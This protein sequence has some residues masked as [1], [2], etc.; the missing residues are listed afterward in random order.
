MLIVFILAIKFNKSLFILL[1][2]QKLTLFSFLV[3]F[4]IN[5]NIYYINTIDVIGN[6]YNILIYLDLR[7]FDLSF[8][9]KITIILFKIKLSI[10]LK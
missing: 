4:S 10:F 2:I 3:K 7:F 9:P 1:Q 5:K 6:L 8:N